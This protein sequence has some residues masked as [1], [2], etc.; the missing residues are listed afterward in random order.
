MN[1]LFKPLALIGLVFTILPAL[2][3]LSGTIEIGMTKTL[4]IIG[5]VLWYI[6]AVPWLGLSK[7][8]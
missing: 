6:G 8:E 1:K 3:L 7:E 5:M 2:L 4:M